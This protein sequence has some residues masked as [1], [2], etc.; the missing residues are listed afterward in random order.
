MAPPPPADWFKVLCGR[1]RLSPDAVPIPLPAGNVDRS[2][3]LARHAWKVK[4]ADGRDA[5]LVWG[6]SLDRIAANGIAFASACPSIAAAPLFREG[7]AVGGV[8][9]E[10]FVDGVSVDRAA[11]D[12]SLPPD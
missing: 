1:G 4:L 12:G 9:A 5:K 3:E 10:T 11:R 6:P 2:A 8:F 7:L